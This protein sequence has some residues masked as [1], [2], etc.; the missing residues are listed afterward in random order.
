MAWFAFL[1]ESI[2]KCS[3]TLVFILVPMAA[4]FTIIEAHRALLLTVCPLTPHWVRT[5]I[6]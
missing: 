5:F 1:S 4:Y 3:T 2:T 6:N